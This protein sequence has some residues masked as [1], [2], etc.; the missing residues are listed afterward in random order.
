VKIRDRGY[1]IAGCVAAVNASIS[2]TTM[3]M[4]VG[5]VSLATTALL[6][7][8]TGFSIA[9]TVFFLWEATR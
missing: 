9:L 6:G 8:V 4:S 3:V 1:F 7:S 5:Q 2:G